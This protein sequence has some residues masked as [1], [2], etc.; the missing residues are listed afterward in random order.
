[1]LRELAVDLIGPG[2]AFTL[3]APLTIV[4]ADGQSRLITPAA[5]A[6]IWVTV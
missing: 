1:V 3:A 5:A 2:T 6:S 4:L